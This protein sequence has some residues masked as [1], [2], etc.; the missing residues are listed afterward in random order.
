MKGRAEHRDDD[1]VVLGRQRPA[2]LLDVREQ[3]DEIGR[4]GAPGI[5]D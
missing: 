5:V 3:R 2:A 1:L 4:R